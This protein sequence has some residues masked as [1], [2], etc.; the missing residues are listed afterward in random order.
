MRRLRGSRIAMILQD[1]MASLNPAITVGEQ[2]AETLALHRGLRGHA[3]DERVRGAAAP[4]ADQRSR[5]ARE[6]VSTSDERR[7]PP[8]RGRG[9]RHLV[10]AESLDRRRAHDLARRHDPGPVP[11]S[12]EGHPARDQSRARLRHPR[13]RHRREAV[14]S[15]GRHVRGTDRRDGDDTRDLQPSAPSVHDRS[16][17]LP[18]DAP[19]RARAAHCDRRPAAGPRPYTVRLLRS[20][21]AARWPRP[22]ARRRRRRCSLSSPITS[23][24]AC[25]PTRRRPPTAS[26]TVW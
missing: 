3:L 22:D 26:C 21:H 18:A 2:I 9:H 23:W 10:P 11:A 15:R 6:G 16:P 13:P 12:P 19:A 8:A 17:Q 7:H 20:L 4:G 25:A 1:P 14:R 5:A 24:P